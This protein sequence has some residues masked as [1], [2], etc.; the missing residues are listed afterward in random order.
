[1][2][3][4]EDEIG[5]GTDHSGIIVLPDSAVVGTPAKDYY[6]I[7]SDFV[8]EIDITPNRVDATSHYGVARDLAA[9]LKQNGK[10]AT[11]K[12]PNVDAFK[13]DV[14]APAIDVE[15]ENKEAW[16]LQPASSHL[17]EQ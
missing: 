14:E 17:S 9:Y 10:P 13:I 12:R 16:K 15:I 7:K 11:L 8:I 2:I 1:M 4:A 3:C 6:N 5:I